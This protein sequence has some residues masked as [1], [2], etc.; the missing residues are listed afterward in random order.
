MRKE[1]STFISNLVDEFSPQILE[2]SSRGSDCEPNRFRQKLKDA[3][4]G[5]DMPDQIDAEYMERWELGVEKK[6]YDIWK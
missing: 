2:F 5:G 3:A 1:D 4:Y 6:L